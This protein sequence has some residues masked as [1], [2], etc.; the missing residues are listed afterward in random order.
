MPVLSPG[1]GDGS[2]LSPGSGR[3]AACHYTPEQ[4]QPHR[5]GR[6]RPDGPGCS[7]PG[8][9]AGA[10]SATR[11]S[12]KGGPGHLVVWVG[13]GRHRSC[14]GR[15]PRAVDAAAATTTAVGGDCSLH[16]GCPEPS[17]VMADP[18]RSAATCCLRPRRVRRHRGRVDTRCDAAST[19]SGRTPASSLLATQAGRRSR[20]RAFAPQPHRG[21]VRVR[22]PG[23]GRSTPS[24]RRTDAAAPPRWQSGCRLETQSRPW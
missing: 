8:I 10:P 7:S 1:R 23:R 19:P 14:A 15:C 6:R 2:D 12:S 20:D 18:G 9:P 11:R 13:A 24:R 3:G 22:L 21:R 4:R 5:A 17:P 16:P